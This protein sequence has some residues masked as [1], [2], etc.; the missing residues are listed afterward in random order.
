MPVQDDFLLS[1]GELK[2]AVRA[3]EQALFRLIESNERI[4]SEVSN[5]RNVQDTVEGHGQALL[6]LERRLTNQE[7]KEKSR[8]AK[9]E[10]N[11]NWIKAIIGFVG[12]VEGGKVTTWV[13]SL[14]GGK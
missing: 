8:T 6:D 14:F 10:Q 4:A 12:L 11:S 2:G 5:L 3:L 1:F 13:I 7:D 9:M